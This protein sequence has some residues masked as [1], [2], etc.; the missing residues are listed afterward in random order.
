MDAL[1]AAN[2]AESLCRSGFYDYSVRCLSLLQETIQKSCE[3]NQAGVKSSSRDKSFSGTQIMTK[4]L[5]L[6]R[7]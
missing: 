1:K 5:P 6:K 4:V 3:F 2:Y 7:F